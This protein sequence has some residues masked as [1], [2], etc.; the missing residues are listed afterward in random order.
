M[1]ELKAWL[2]DRSISPSGSACERDKSVLSCPYT[3]SNDLLSILFLAIDTVRMLHAEIEAL[4]EYTARSPY[5]LWFGN[6]AEYAD[7]ELLDWQPEDFVDVPRWG[8]EGDVFKAAEE[9]DY[10]RDVV[11]W[12]MDKIWE[13]RAGQDGEDRE[14]REDGKRDKER[15]EQRRRCLGG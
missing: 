14:D 10:L 2:N 13:A 3:T 11:G 9:V 5:G 1:D 15:R 6:V 12:I 7:Y 8:L 4:L